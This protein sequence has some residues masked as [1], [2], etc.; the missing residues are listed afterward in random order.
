MNYAPKFNTDERAAKKSASNPDWYKNYVHAQFLDGGRN[1]H[2]GVD[3]WGLICVIYKQELGI[4]LPSYED[5]PALE[6]DKVATTLA[7]DFISYPWQEVPMAEMKSFDLVILGGLGRLRGQFKWFDS[8]IGIVTKPPFVMH[9]EDL[10]G[11]QSAPLMN[12]N[13]READRDLVKRFR[14]VLRYVGP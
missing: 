1:M 14:R 8:H 12:V 11:L 9:I 3:C 2:D 4:T 10:P 13:G 6:I 5:V 7:K